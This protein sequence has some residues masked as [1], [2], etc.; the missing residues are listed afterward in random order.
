M[1]VI[2]GVQPCNAALLGREA[3]VY[4]SLRSTRWTA[5]FISGALREVLIC[6]SCTV[7]PAR[8]MRRCPSGTTSLDNHSSRSCTKKDN[9]GQ[10]ECWLPD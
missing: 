2:A 1:S 5:D 9:Q 7:L 8:V 4:T 6:S 3:A 10:A